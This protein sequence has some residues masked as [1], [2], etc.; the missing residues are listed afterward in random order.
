MRKVLTVLAVIVLVVAIGL[1][2]GMWLT[3]Q[4]TGNSGGNGPV[5]STGGGEG[6]VLAQQPEW[7]PAVEVISVPG[8]AES[9]ADDN[10][11]AP[12][13]NPNSLLLGVTNPLSASYSPKDVKVWTTPYPA[14][15]K[16]HQMPDQLTYD[17]SQAVGRDVTA[18][19]MSDLHAQCP[20]TNFVM[21]GFSQGAAIAGDLAEQIGAGNGPVP[22]ERVSGVA[23]LGDPRR[24]PSQGVNE[25]VQLSGVGIELSLQPVSPIVSAV[26]PGATMRGPRGGFG[27]LNDRVHNVCVPGDS[28][29]DVPPAVPDAIA[30]ANEM[31]AMAGAHA[32]YAV[33]DAAIPGTTPIAWTEGWARALIDQAMAR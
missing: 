31:L 16:T 28:F 9:R 18:K 15:I 32:T 25:N 11:T 29:C 2:A 5:P 4:N 3:G 26:V 13:A 6:G 7:C 27:P 30:R 1:G 23:L 33:N 8:T 17:D 12:T 22:A 10:P 19:E 14:Q 24:N 20:L 21:M